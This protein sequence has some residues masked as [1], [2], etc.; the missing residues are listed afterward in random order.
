MTS[1]TIKEDTRIS[2]RLVVGLLIATAA[3]V[4]A[5]GDI[6]YQLRDVKKE[7][8]NLRAEVE[9]TSLDR[10]YKIDDAL[11]MRDFASKN[12]LILIPHLTL[13]E[14]TLLGNGAP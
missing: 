6:R 1:P 4:G 2:L 12:G 7:V 14:A 11:Y 3:S 5:W 9:K 10:W 8:E 13:K